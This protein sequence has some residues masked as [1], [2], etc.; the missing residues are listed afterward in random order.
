[1]KIA[2]RFVGTEIS[3]RQALKP[4]PRILCQAQ[5][6]T[7][8]KAHLEQASVKLSLFYSKM[9]LNPTYFRLLPGAAHLYHPFTSS[10]RCFPESSE[11]GGLAHDPEYCCLFTLRVQS[12]VT[13]SVFLSANI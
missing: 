5:T 10:Q 2:C 4:Q 8:R 13:Y 1:M 7:Y 6:P 9:G 11:A 3:I 12:P